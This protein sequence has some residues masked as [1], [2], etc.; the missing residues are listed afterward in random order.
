MYTH[1]LCKSIKRREISVSNKKS[2]VARI[3]CEFVVN[4]Y[5]Q[6]F[7]YETISGE[8]SRSIFY[9]N[10]EIENRSLVA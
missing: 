2:S 9:E 6:L 10:E 3:E 7:L 1:D 5:A 8:K 4:L